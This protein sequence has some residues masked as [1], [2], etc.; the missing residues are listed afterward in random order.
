MRCILK[1]QVD[2]LKI[3]GPN[4]GCHCMPNIYRTNF[5]M[6]PITSWTKC[7]NNTEYEICSHIMTTCYYSKMVKNACPTNC[8][9]MEID[10]KV[11]KLNGISR[12]VKSNEMH[13]LIKFRTMEIE[14]HDEV[15][16]QEIYNFIGTVGGSLGLFIGFSYTGFVG[17]ILDYFIRV[18]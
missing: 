15:W 6:Y 5:E 11:S 3:D 12:L 7:K 4:A 8:K 1:N 10:G 16:I 9:R 13:V 14:E 18:N 2:C 17:Q